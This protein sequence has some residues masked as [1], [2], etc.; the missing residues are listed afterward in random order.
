M[1][2]GPKMAVVPGVVG[3][4]AEGYAY[5]AIGS[6]NLIIQLNMQKAHLFQQVL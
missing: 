3:N 1:K 4:S 2:S 6:A 5:S